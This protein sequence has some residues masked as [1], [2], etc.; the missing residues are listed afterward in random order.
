MIDFK[1]VSIPLISLEFPL[2]LGLCWACAAYVLSACARAPPR[3][4]HVLTL[5][6]QRMC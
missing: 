5:T 4:L 1:G 2:V 3:A 6:G